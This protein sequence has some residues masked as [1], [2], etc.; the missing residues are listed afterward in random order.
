MKAVDLIGTAIA[1]TFRS[2]TRTLLTILAIF[3]GAFTLTLTNGLG[4]GI[5]AY[6]DD[7]VDGVGASDVMTVSKTSES[8][9]G[10]GSGP[11]E[12]DP[13]AVASGAAGPP[14][15]TVV[16][17]TPADLDTLA[18][19]EGVLDVQA[20]KS[21]SADYV[22]AG[23][24]GAKYV[25]GIGSLV[26][27]QTVQL[28]AGAALDD[29]STQL[30]A[31]LPV[32]YVEPL[33]FADDAAAVG[34]TLSI[35]ITDAQRTPH[36]VEATIVGVAEESIAGAG[37]GLVTNDALTDALFTTQSVGVPADQVDRFA[38]AS[39]RFDAAADDEQ[40]TALK[41]RLADAGYTGT[42][43]ADQL[44]TIKAVVDGIV[45]VL[46]AFA[47]IALLAASFGIVNTLLM[48][49]QERTREIGLMKAM[50]MGSGRVFALFSIEAAFIGFLGS[51]I[52]ALL[53][54]VAG[55]GLSGVLSGSL[56]SDLPGLTLI[57]FDPVS[58]LTVVLVVMLIA[59]VAG[60]LPAARAARADP[61]Q[62]LRYE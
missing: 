30:Q 11:V 43:V 50:G 61:V 27:G 23:D 29:A 48:S 58:I 6:I 38:Q 16:A 57:A 24:D 45:L 19:V 2:R 18:G 37:G 59:F 36:V 60:T 3:V 5:N 32:S 17:L 21:I 35:G 46:N 40:V 10:L 55:T 49:V 41:D 39:V 26:E 13:D 56:L 33:G 44:G 4:T 28:A 22:A 8:A 7:T 54:V 20:V 42:T 1:N 15:Q 14:G 25:I 12:Y 31:V 53:A 34:T 47:V 52:G 9:T 62:S 51:A